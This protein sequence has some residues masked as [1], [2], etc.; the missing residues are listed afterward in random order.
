M[1]VPV[2]YVESNSTALEFI[3]GGRA[4]GPSGRAAS[5]IVSTVAIKDLNFAFRIDDIL[6]T[7]ESITRFVLI[8]E[9]HSGVGYLQDGCAVK[10]SAIV[11]PKMNTA[12]VLE[13][14]L[15]PFS[16]RQINLS[17][18]ISRTGSTGQGLYFFIEVDGDVSISDA[19]SELSTIAN[20]YHFPLYQCF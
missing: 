8:G 13:Q 3:S 19:L 7:T 10:S 18:I 14:I 16:Q 6:D 12:G 15:R 4:V 9:S 17:S 1:G 5:A 20:I 11:A 2:V